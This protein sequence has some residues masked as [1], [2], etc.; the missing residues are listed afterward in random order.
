MQKFFSFPVP[1]PLYTFCVQQNLFL[2]FASTDGEQKGMLLKRSMQIFVLFF[3][4]SPPVL[5]R[6]TKPITYI[7]L[8]KIRRCKSTFLP[9]TKWYYKRISKK[10]SLEYW[11]QHVA[12]YLHEC[13]HASQLCPCLYLDNCAFGSISKYG[14]PN[15]L[16]G[17]R[18]MGRK[19]IT[20]LE[21]S[22]VSPPRPSANSSIKGKI[23]E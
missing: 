10:P 17:G 21:D 12:F 23:L 16:V 2:Q 19:S 8:P 22:Q 7:I 1:V 14:M 13:L 15:F 4:T 20:S 5:N 6:R 11:K 9:H 3:S 18:G